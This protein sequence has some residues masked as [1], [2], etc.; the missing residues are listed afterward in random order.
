MKNLL[1]T[2]AFIL[3]LSASAGAATTGS[4]VTLSA[5]QEKEYKKVETTQVPV[6]IL[7]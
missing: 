6:D 7:K 3:S 2:T 1:L 5:Y 4:V